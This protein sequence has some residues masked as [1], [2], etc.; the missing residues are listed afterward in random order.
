VLSFSNTIV[1]SWGK[2]D[3]D[4]QARR[5]YECARTKSL[6]LGKTTML[7]FL[8]MTTLLPSTFNL[9]YPNPIPVEL[10]GRNSH[11]ALIFPT[12]HP[13]PLPILQ[14]RMRDTIT[15][16]VH[17]ELGSIN[18]TP[19]LEAQIDVLVKGCLGRLRVIRVKPRWKEWSLAMKSLLLDRSAENEE[20]NEGGMDLVVC[21]GFSDGF[22]AERWAEEST[23]ARGM[24]SRIGIRGGE[25]TIGDVMDDI[26]RLRK[27]LGAV[28][29]LSVQGLWVCPTS[30]TQLMI[31]LKPRFLYD[32]PT[33]TLP[34]PI[35]PRPT[36]L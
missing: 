27:D 2:D 3:P 4:S 6:L 23:K 30:L 7:L 20:E 34:E 11:A 35:L 1:K 26:T 33:L 12:S 31:G 14:R 18:S 10:G 25:V 9:K 8:L 15:S 19:E 28:I 16:A 29:I 24:K 13:N 5:N 32:P 17:A 22:W 36:G 21:D